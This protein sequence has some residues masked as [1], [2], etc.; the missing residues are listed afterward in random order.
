[1]ERSPPPQA[2]YSKP[3]L[4]PAGSY[5]WTPL[6]L[7][8]LLFFVIGFVTWLNGPLISFVRVSF[9]LDD[10][11][12]FL[13]PLVFYFSY[14][15]FA[16]PSSWIVQR[17]GLK[18]S[19]SVALG[20]MALGMA[21]TGQFMATG[22]YHG[23]LVGLLSVGSG[24]ALLQTAV[25]PYVS[26]LGPL[27]KA[28]Q[29]IAIMGIC[30]KFAGILAPVTLAFFVMGS[31]QDVATHAS[32]MTDPIAREALLH[33]F[34]QSIYWPYL[35]MALFMVLTA[36]AVS[37]SS[38]PDIHAPEKS[39]TATREDTRSKFITIIT[40][41]RILCGIIAMFLYV[42]VEVLA[43]DAI[44]TYAQDLGL[45]LNQ[46]RFFTALTLTGMLV[47]YCLGMLCTPRFCSQERYTLYC[48]IAGGF[49]SLMA[50]VA[51]GYGAVLC[52]ALLGVANAMIFPGLFPT[53]LKNT[54]ALAPLVSALLV[55]AYC[56]GGVLPQLFVGLKTIFGFQGVF[57]SLTLCGY[58]FIALYMRS[59]PAR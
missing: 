7:T 23:A 13:I 27:H 37:L 31:I 3:D 6:A 35:T 19:L 18:R 14:F 43:G 39:D 28:A 46:T 16:I 32:Q 34:V 4:C 33:Q 21:C 41:P 38:L 50:F 40:S 22:L 59:N 2:T 57:T 44:G 29:R 20:I 42:G 12:A 47:G 9:S 25:N 5:G 58:G 26:F 45:S 51:H 8:A 56:G 10:K 1:M 36:I 30:N 15:L 49:L 54:G 52:L 24:L 53:V 55:M 48:C 11:A 17:I